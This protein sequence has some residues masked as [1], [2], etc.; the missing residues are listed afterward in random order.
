VTIDPNSDDEINQR[1]N[2]T[3]LCLDLNIQDL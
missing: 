2:I 3:E 1:N